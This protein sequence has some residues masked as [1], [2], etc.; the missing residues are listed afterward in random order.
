MAR[1]AAGQPI[2]GRLALVLALGALA[3]FAVGALAAAQV[4]H[5]EPPRQPVASA[6][7]AP[8]AEARLPDA[9][10][11]G[12]AGPGAAVARVDAGW[13]AEVAA[14]TGIPVRALFAYASAALVLG[15]E[16]PECGLGWNTLA[17]LG[18]IESDHG[19]H[20]GSVLGEDGFPAPAIRGPALD[21]AGVAA[22]ADT[23]GDA[24]DGDATW[25]RAMGPLQVIPETW[26]RWGA[27]ADGDGRAS[28]DDIDDAALAAARYLCADGS[29]SSPEEWR[30]AVFSYNHLDSYVDA[31]ADAANRYA[32]AVSG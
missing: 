9:V 27:D 28:P 26:R 21:G 20:G 18:A 16:A 12:A 13:A 3:A 4:T 30:R 24:W 7:S 31:V 11:D 6:S 17:G 10:E 22:I 19:R 23:D 8:V 32:A 2:L 25:D 14:A 15:A 29:V 5:R 1:S